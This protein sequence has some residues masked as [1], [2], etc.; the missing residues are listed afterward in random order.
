MEWFSY[1][2]GELSADL[3]LAIQQ[4]NYGNKF[5]PDEIAGLWTANNDARNY[6]VLGDPAV[7]LKVE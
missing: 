7:R 6:A 5:D 3:T 2:Y 4:M 1:R